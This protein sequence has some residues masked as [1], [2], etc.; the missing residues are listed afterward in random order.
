MSHSHSKLNFSNSRLKLTKKGEFA[1]RSAT[2]NTTISKKENDRN[3][4]IKKTYTIKDIILLPK[5]HIGITINN[6]KR[7]IIPIKTKNNSLPY[8]HRQKTI[9]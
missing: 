8:H 3:K 1:S 9:I 2:K 5:N 6:Y 7:P 4:S